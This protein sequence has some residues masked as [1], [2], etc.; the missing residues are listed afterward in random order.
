MITAGSN[1]TVS[2]LQTL[3]ISVSGMDCAECTQHVQKA[4]ATLN[5]V[6]SLPDLG[7]LANSS[8]LLRQK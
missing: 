6:Q 3:E 5:G 4:I 2:Q 8:R 7:I 1:P